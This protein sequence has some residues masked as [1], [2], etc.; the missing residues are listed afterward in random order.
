MMLFCSRTT[1]VC[2]TA[3][4]HLICGN[5]SATTT[6][7][8]SWKVKTYLFRQRQTLT[9]HCIMT[10]DCHACLLT[11]LIMFSLSLTVCPNVLLSH[12][13]SAD[14]RQEIFLW[15]IWNYIDLCI[16]Y[17]WANPVKFVDHQFAADPALDHT[18]TLRS[19]GDEIS[20]G[21]GRCRWWRCGRSSWE[22]LRAGGCHRCTTSPTLLELWQR[23]RL[24][25]LHQLHLLHHRCTA[26]VW[27]H[28]MLTSRRYRAEETSATKC[29]TVYW[30][31]TPVRRQTVRRLSTEWQNNWKRGHDMQ[32]WAK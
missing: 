4:R 9:Q 19:G 6:S 31:F 7:D 28:E 5:Y 8:A 27:L 2:E 20:D 26:D 13:K 21:L 14:K 18:Q 23:R 12:C 16:T 32:P 11:Y 30:A 22:R 1:L 15:Y 10:S 24:W 17:Q 3:C 25:Q 29:R